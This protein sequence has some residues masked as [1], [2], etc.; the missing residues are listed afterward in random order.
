MSVPGSL[1][2]W[3]DCITLNIRKMCPRFDC[4]LVQ[5]DNM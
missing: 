3:F 4:F 1:A 2:N 5:V